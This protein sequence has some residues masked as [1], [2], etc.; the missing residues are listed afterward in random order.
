MKDD[1]E[2]ERWEAVSGAVLLLGPRGRFGPLR[3]MEA[4]GFCWER[5]VFGGIS[6]EGWFSCDIVAGRKLKRCSD[7]RTQSTNNKCGE[8]YR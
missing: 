4:D 7:E 1:A 3:R 2:R 5:E 6:S 8:N